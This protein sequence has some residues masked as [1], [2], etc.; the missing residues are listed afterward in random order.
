MPKVA[1]TCSKNSPLSKGGDAEGS[2]GLRRP[3][4]QRPTQTP[5]QRQKHRPCPVGRVA[6]PSPTK[7][8]KIS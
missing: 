6:K 2:V 8:P 5:Q 1:R 7:K 3:N 4:L